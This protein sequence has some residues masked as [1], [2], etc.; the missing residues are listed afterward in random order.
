MELG[1]E[2]KESEKEENKGLD[3]WKGLG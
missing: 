3:M 2:N 1:R